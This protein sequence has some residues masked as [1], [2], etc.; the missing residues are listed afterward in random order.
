MW[1]PWESRGF[2]TLTVAPVGSARPLAGVPRPSEQN[3]P[4]CMLNPGWQNHSWAL[5]VWVTVAA[6]WLGRA[7]CFMEY[8][9]GSKL[10]T[11]QSLFPNRSVHSTLLL[12]V[13][14]FL[15]SVGWLFP[16]Q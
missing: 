10:F 4:L 12:L 11:P 13:N 6:A 1:T 14:S 9:P 16:G 5:P 15:S 3:S 8:L 2:I 7:R